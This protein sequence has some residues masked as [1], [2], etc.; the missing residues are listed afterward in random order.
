MDSDL[1][2]I[3]EILSGMDNAMLMCE[4][5]GDCLLL[6]SCMLQKTKELFD[7]LIGE[8]GRKMMFDKF[9]TKSDTK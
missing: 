3:D 8:K 9:G 7:D 2:R 6:A 1:V 5:Y 4:D